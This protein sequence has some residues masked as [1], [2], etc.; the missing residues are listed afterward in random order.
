MSLGFSLS[1]GVGLSYPW[2]LVALVLALLPLV[3]MA[4]WSWICL[5]KKPRIWKWP[6]TSMA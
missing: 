4:L 6:A 1:L 2:V 3:W 5:L